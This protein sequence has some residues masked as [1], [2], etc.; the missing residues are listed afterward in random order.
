MS[1]VLPERW[2]ALAATQPQWTP[3]RIILQEKGLYR[4]WT[5]QGEQNARV[6]GKLQFEARSP[7]DYP[8]VGDYVLADTEDPDIAIIHQLLPRASLLLRR[9]AGGSRLEQ[10]VA[11]NVDTLFLCMSLNRDFNLRRLERYLSIAWDSGAV[12]VVVLT[13]TDLCSDLPQCLQAIENIAVGVDILAV[14][15]LTED[16]QQLLPYL[17]AGRTVAFVG[18]SGVGKSTLINCLLGEARLATG[19]LRGDDRGRHT[20]TH[21][22][23]LLLPQ[24]AMVIDTPGMRELGLWDAAAGVEQTFQDIEILIAQCRFRNCSHT[25]EPG[26]AVQTALQCG[27]LDAGRW[28]SYQKLQSEHAYA[29]DRAGHQAA[30]TKR[31]KEISQINKQ[32]RKK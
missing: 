25:G 9:A 26:C 28:R 1:F 3:G 15:A 29:A 13:K 5:H 11:A 21:R 32:N 8:T 7:S 31:F 17:T 30:K 2:R 19:G 16:C 23:L 18:S 6:S 27:V 22:E 12:P 14:S 20:T 10:A 24:G 4:L